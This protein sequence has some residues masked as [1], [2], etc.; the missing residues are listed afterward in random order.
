M[1]D[2]IAES[3]EGEVRLLKFSDLT[4]LGADIA[5]PVDGTVTEWTEF[6]GA[7]PDEALG[8]TGGKRCP[9]RSVF[10][11]SGTRYELFCFRFIRAGHRS[12]RNVW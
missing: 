9:P 5:N 11:R 12:R 7:L 3:L 8:V 4:Q 2:K 10:Q 6:T 1:L